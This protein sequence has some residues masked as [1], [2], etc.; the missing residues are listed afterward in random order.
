V[1]AQ[2][3]FTANPREL[4]GGLVSLC[5]ALL[6]IGVVA[7]VAGLL[8]D[9]ATTWRAF[10]V[11]FLYFG[12]LSEGALC[13]ACALVIIGARWAGPIRH[14]AEGLAA[15]IPI[16][17]VLFLVS[18]YFGRE[19]IH[20]NWIH[21]APPGREGW[22]S[23]GRVF[24]TDAGVMFLGT[25]LALAFLRAS[26]RPTLEGAAARAPRAAGMFERWT[27]GW[28][29]A[30]AEREASAH[31]LGVLAPIIAL[32]YAFGFSFIA[33]DQVMSLQPS[34]YSTIF[35]WYFL[36]GGFLCGVSATALVC[37]LLRATNPEWEAQITKNR[38]HDLGK[39]V[40]AFSIFWMY[41]FFSQYLVIWYGNLPEETQFFQAR[42]GT[43]FLQDTW[44]WVWA[45][46]DQPYAKLA[47]A[48]W[49]GC[50]ITP[51]LVLL[52]ERPKRTPAI[53]GGVSAFVLLG[54]WLE[55][56]ALV[57]PALVPGDGAAWFG[58]IQLGIALGFLGGFVLVFLIFSR[59][60]P[61]LPLPRRS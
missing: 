34:W 18:N 37:V 32:V 16:S 9:Q 11:N 31:R 3:P 39:M 26:F 47:L 25:V 54:F 8:T 2:A 50:W 44:F 55:R 40:F 60:F 24:A 12:M 53:L 36:W 15:W 33:F 23:F 1:S 35:G 48:A 42:L 49:V 14:V 57:W 41:L 28:R 17:F 59:I 56:N 61:T 46:L 10:H 43:Q 20:T 30:E 19:Y 5:I 22:L 7:F 21:G 27:A 13:L 38:M 6:A 58:P 4:P 45:R 29:G 52:G 51:F